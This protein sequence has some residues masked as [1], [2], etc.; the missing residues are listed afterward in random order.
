MG[1][2]RDEIIVATP[3]VQGR[4]GRETPTHVGFIE[5]GVRG[6]ALTPAY[7]LA[8]LP[9]AS[10][11]EKLGTFG[12]GGIPANFLHGTNQPELVGQ[13]LSSGEVRIPD[14]VLAGL[15]DEV[16]PGVPVI[17]FDSVAVDRDEVLAQIPIPAATA[18]SFP[19]GGESALHG[20]SDVLP[21][22]WRRCSPG[23]ALPA[24]ELLC[25][26]SGETPVFAAGNDLVHIYATA[27]QSN[28]QCF[29]PSTVDDP[30][31]I[32][33][34]VVNAPLYPVTVFDQPLVLSVIEWTPDRRWLRVR[35]PVLPH[36]TAV[37]VEGKY[38]ELSASTTRI[39]VDIGASRDLGRGVLTVFEGSEEV[40]TAAISAGRETRP[41]TP[42]TT[43]ID[44]IVP[45]IAPAY[46]PTVFST[47]S[48]SE[49]L[50]TYGGG[51][52]PTQSIHGLSDELWVAH[53]EV[54]A[55]SGSIHTSAA[56][57]EPLEEFDM[58]G[59]RV[60]IFDSTNPA[61]DFDTVRYARVDPARTVSLSELPVNDPATWIPPVP[62]F[63]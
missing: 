63:T 37:W 32:D 21:Q 15:L 2:R 35:A 10:F 12:G 61:A 6:E 53:R 25:R 22:L 1:S 16:T 7:G 31:A 8:A 59:A 55:G 49:A 57:T 54:P 41:T 62:S 58:L 3:I 13:R 46:G 27:I 52:I 51:G 14:P 9:I 60:I 40:F 23:D 56:T 5:N 28:L 19:I 4:D 47:A 30:T 50:G 43:H 20:A 26:T 39:E 34:V 44:Q 36:N 17:I 48:F 33:A 42:I 11:S 24:S 45:D 29:V 38:F 18:S